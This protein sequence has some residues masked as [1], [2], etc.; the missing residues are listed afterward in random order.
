[1]RSAGGDDVSVDLAPIAPELRAGVAAFPTYDYTD[2]AVRRLVTIGSRMA[3]RTEVPGV[4]TSEERAGAVRYRLYRPERAGGAALVWMHPGGMVMGSPGQSDA[5]CAHTAA[6]LGLTIASVDYRLAPQQPFPAALDDCHAVW[7]EVLARAAEWGV[8]PSRVAVG[9]QSAGGGMA[10][11]L[12]Q[13]LLDEGA[14]VPAAQLLLYPS[15][16]DR[17]AARTELDELAHPIWDNASNRFGW[18]SYLGH[19]PGLAS[20]APYAAA[21]RREDLTGLAP[22]WIGVGALDLFLDESRRY[23]ERLRLA[24]VDATLDEVPGAPHGFDTACPDAP[25]VVDF[26]DRA[27]TWLDQRLGG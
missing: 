20:V 21:A 15:L 13:R 8:D 26:L 24:G 22:A 19:P 5:L 9:G 23:A 4:L 14:T 18:Q 2:A 27:T 7:S 3:P 12:A 17:T 25:L 16:D 1:M 11:C 6:R 10:A